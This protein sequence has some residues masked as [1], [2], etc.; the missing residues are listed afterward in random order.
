MHYIAAAWH[1]VSQLTVRNCFH[2]AGFGNSETCSNEDSCDVPV[3]DVEWGKLEGHASFD[4]YVNIDENVVTAE[5]MTISEIADGIQQEMDEEEDDDDE[6]A[7]QTPVCFSDVV[8]ALETIKRFV[9][10]RNV[11]DE[12]MTQLSRFEGTVYS[13]AAEKKKQGKITDFFGK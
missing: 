5:A 2:K 4:D 3:D 10:R 12:I 8:N 11:S 6:Q 9:T 13:I 1:R 7:T